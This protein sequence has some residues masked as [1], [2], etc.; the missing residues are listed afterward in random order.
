MSPKI[1]QALAKGD[2][3]AFVSPSARMHDAIPWRLERAT[4][5]LERAGY[6]VKIIHDPQ[7]PKSP[8]SAN[9]AAR[10]EEVHSAFR[11]PAVKAIVCCIGGSTVNQL[12][13]A[14]DPEIIRNN[15]K[16]LTGG[17]DNTLMHHFC[18]V[19]GL[20]TFYGPSAINHFG[21]WPEPLSF[22]WE[23]F[24]KVTTVQRPAGSMPRSAEFSEESSDR[25]TEPE[26]LANGTMRARALKPARG[27]RWLQAGR[28]EGEIWG[29]C[30]PS[31]LQMMNTKWEVSYH[32]KVAFIGQISPILFGRAVY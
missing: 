25:K 11:D 30:L 28:A 6:N 10:A 4:A 29:G 27:W 3:I 12:L 1:P 8:L 24:F 21:E 5:V 17:S 18:Y 15:P 23:H 2:T 32:G 9:I 22:T 20:R 19:N 13:P 31:L 26:R 14:L 16:I 7:V